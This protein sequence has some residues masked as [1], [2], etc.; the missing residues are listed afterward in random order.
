MIDVFTLSLE[1]FFTIVALGLFGSAWPDA[2]RS[3]LWEI[4]GIKGWN[5]NPRLRVYYYA[6]Y[7]EPPAI[8][9][10]WSQEYTIRIIFIPK[11]TLIKRLQID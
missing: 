11:P 3:I 7:E 10:I 4:G 8:P 1:A 6:N 9:F 5:S 2:Y